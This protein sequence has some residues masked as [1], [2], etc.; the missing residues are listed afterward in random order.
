MS[1]ETPLPSLSHPEHTNNILNADMRS[2]GPEA[3]DN[4]PSVWA[5]KAK[6]RPWA[7]GKKALRTPGSL[8]NRLQKL[9]LKREPASRERREKLISGISM[10]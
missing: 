9:E 2:E 10:A 3:Q 7:C 4:D 1:S 8:L 6:N 5:R